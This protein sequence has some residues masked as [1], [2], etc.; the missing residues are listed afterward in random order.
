[1][2]RCFFHR[3]AQAAEYEQSLAARVAELKANALAQEAAVREQEQLDARHAERLQVRSAYISCVLPSMFVSCAFWC[4]CE[5]VSAIYVCVLVC[6][7]VCF[8]TREYIAIAGSLGCMC[9]ILCLC[10][11]F[12]VCFLCVVCVRTC[13]YYMCSMSSNFDHL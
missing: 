7:W 12:F 2:G 8:L 6:W 1:M 5:C 11:Y 13:L 9:L 4:C 10:V 3:Q